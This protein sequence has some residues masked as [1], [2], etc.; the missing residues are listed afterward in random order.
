MMI[1]SW[2]FKLLL[3]LFYLI[4]LLRILFHTLNCFG[5][6]Y[7]AYITHFY[8]LYYCLTLNILLKTCHLLWLFRLML[9][10][11][12]SSMKRGSWGRRLWRFRW[13]W[14]FWLFFLKCYFIWLLVQLI[15]F[16]HLI[17]LLRIIEIG[18]TKN[19]RTCV[20]ILLGSRK[21]I[22][23]WWKFWRL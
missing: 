21:E 5:F 2:W 6:F 14:L 23:P 8:L 10:W 18:I 1:A 16:N 11:K 17:V 9:L 12:K 3:Y 19:I 20:I 7:H 4:L 15:L 13:F 22:H